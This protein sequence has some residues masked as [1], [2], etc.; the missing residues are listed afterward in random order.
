MS[1]YQVAAFALFVVLV[2]PSRVF[3]WLLWAGQAR[4]RRVWVRPEVWPGRLWS[5]RQ[6]A[7]LAVFVCLMILG[8][9]GVVVET[10]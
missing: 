1:G 2:T 7:A 6:T 3:G 8:L 5:H 10:V 9:S 4:L